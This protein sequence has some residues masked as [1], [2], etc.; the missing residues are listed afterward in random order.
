MDVTEAEQLV[1]L[2]TVQERV[3]DWPESI[4][5]GLLDKF[6]EGAGTAMQFPPLH[7]PGQFSGLVHSKP[8]PSLLAPGLLSQE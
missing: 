3:V 1:A 5:P 6:T 8:H 2:L 4:V 7:P